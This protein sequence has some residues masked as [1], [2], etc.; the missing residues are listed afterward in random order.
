MSTPRKKNTGKLKR[1]RPGGD[2]PVSESMEIQIKNNEQKI[3]NLE[4]IITTLHNSIKELN[5]HKQI[6]TDDIQQ[7]T[8]E[9]RNAQSLVEV[10]RKEL[11]DLKQSQYQFKEEMKEIRKDIHETRTESSNGFSELKGMLSQLITSKT[12]QTSNVNMDTEDIADLNERKNLHELTKSNRNDFYKLYGELNRL[13]TT[14]TNQDRNNKLPDD[15]FQKYKTIR[16]SMTTWMKTGLA[17]S[18]DLERIALKETTI[19]KDRPLLFTITQFAN[20]MT[21]EYFLFNKLTKKVN[22]EFEETYIQRANNTLF[23]LNIE[24]KQSIDKLQSPQKNQILIL[25]Y[26]IARN[27]SSYLFKKRTTTNRNTDISHDTQHFQQGPRN[28]GPRNSGPNLNVRREQFQT[29]ADPSREQFQTVTDSSRRFVS[30]EADAPSRQLEINPRDTH[31]F[32]PQIPITCQPSFIPSPPP[33]QPYPLYHHQQQ[34]EQYQPPTL[35]PIQHQELPM[36]QR[37]ERKQR[38]QH[39]QQYPSL[40]DS[41]KDKQQRGSPHTS[42]A[43][44]CE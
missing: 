31:Q 18:R 12:L 35:Q 24:M 4:S 34:Q 11:D 44:E 9:S 22:S 23:E 19:E 32:V 40:Q 27:N 15:D 28:L 25:A 30:I 6:H 42:R 37:A 20:S 17:L 3:S 14:H 33:Q 43:L 21:D 5:S 41:G 7:L 16:K 39:L 13:K 36:Q 2:S 1:K 10:L 8:A 38:Q 26:S 29:V